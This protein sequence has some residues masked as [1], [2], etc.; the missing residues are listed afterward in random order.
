MSS[1]KVKDKSKNKERIRV[2]HS[3]VEEVSNS[4]MPAENVA[5]EDIDDT[6][7]EISGPTQDNSN[8]DIMKAIMSLKS[9]LY[10]KIDEVQTTVTEVN[11]QMQECTR[12]IAQAEQRISDA[13][14][15]ATLLTARVTTLET[16]VTTLQGTVKSLNEK[17]D[18]LECRSRRNNVRLVGLP[19]KVEG[20]DATAFLE[21]WLPEALNIEQV[22]SVERAHRIG[23]PPDSG[24]D[25]PR[26]LIMKFMN[27]KDRERVLKAAR[28]KG[29][30]TFKN[31]PVRFHVDLSAGVHK[32]QREYDDVR[33][34][35]RDRGIHKHR[36]IYPDRLLVT[37]DERSRTFRTPAEVETFFDSL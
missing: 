5:S 2:E 30:V 21:K 13:E 26:T 37:H 22:G 31:K 17:A 15:A 8:Q 16:K 7:D 35:L 11:R 4:A 1:R 14:D 29:Q 34:R 33:K 20:Q 27:F 3:E 12:R 6:D 19:E 9:G 10:K 36:I 18:D 23:A 24:T 28:T 25:R 32:K